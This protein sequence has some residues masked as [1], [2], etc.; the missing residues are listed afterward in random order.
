[1]PNS[2]K[3][4]VITPNRGL[5]GQPEVAF[6]GFGNSSISLKIPDSTTATLNIESSG[7]NLFSVDSNLSS[8][9]L[10]NITNQSTLPAV[11]V[12]NNKI[13]LGS[14]RGKVIINGQGLKLPK[15]ASN[16]FPPSNEGTLIYDS[17]NSVA[18][19]FNGTR[20]AI[21]GGKKSGLSMD[22]PG[23][24]AEQI[25]MDYPN[26]PDGAYWI[27]PYG[28]PEP[29]LVHCYM[30]IEGGGWMLVLKNSSSELG[31]FGSGSFLVSNWE[32]W[33]V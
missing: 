5:S 27:Q 30:T 2:D 17:T 9:G 32:G 11:S 4:I 21:L 16:N 26:S 1:M 3:N 24:S 7:T 19:C 15:F 29:F 20:W 10:L 18:R 12:N 25:L 14:Q 33:A 28:C 13:T 31:N 6:T 22:N 8:G 23:E